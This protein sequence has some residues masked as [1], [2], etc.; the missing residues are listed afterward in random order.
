MKIISNEELEKLLKDSDKTLDDFEDL[1]HY[2]EF[3]YR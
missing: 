1:E 2:I 3:N